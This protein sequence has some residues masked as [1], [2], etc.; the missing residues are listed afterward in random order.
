MCSQH[1]LRSL[2]VTLSMLGDVLKT[3]I[4]FC[5][6]SSRETVCSQTKW[7][8]L[9]QLASKS[10]LRSLVIEKRLRISVYKALAFFIVSFTI[11]PLT[12]KKG[13]LNV[14]ES[15]CQLI[16]LYS[17][18]LLLTLLIMCFQYSCLA[19]RTILRNSLIFKSVLLFKGILVSKNVLL[20]K[21]F[22]YVIKQFL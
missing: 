17:D 12:S 4:V 11:I 14:K 18:L 10:K 1:A 9:S 20:F 3:L 8:V 7:L 15:L 16:T 21:M 13:A 22:Y 19:L 5:S 2:T 6:T